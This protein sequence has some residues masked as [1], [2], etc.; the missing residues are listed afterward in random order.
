[1]Y[2]KWVGGEAASGDVTPGLATP[3]LASKGASSSKH[4][5]V[6]PQTYKHY[7]CDT[8]NLPNQKMPL[9]IIG[10]V[11]TILAISNITMSISREQADHYIRSFISKTSTTTTSITDGHR[12]DGRTDRPTKQFQKD[13]NYNI[14]QLF[15]CTCMHAHVRGEGLLYKIILTDEMQ[16]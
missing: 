13:D 12:T 1:M 16:C 6:T 10:R 5:F 15:N 7:F 11:I 14:T 9:R 8:T 2:K 4:H 3:N